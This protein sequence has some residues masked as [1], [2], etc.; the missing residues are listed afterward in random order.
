MER[1]DLE[2]DGKTYTIGTIHIAN[3]YKE[4]GKYNLEVIQA[5]GDNTF[6]DPDNL[7]TT[8]SADDLFDGK[9]IS[10]TE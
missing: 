4:N 5:G 9:V 7:R 3:D 2:V 1:R 8:L 10:V 6:T